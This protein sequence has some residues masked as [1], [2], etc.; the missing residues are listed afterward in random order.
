MGR[1]D[2]YL[3]ESGLIPTRSRAKRAILYG[4]IKV[5][6]KIVTK[7]AYSIKPADEVEVISEIATKPMGYWKLHFICTTLHLEIFQSSDVVLDLGSSAGG[8]LEYAAQ[9]CKKVY[10]IEIAA[11]FAPLLQQLKQQYPNIV[12]LLADAFHLDP[13]GPHPIEAIDII[14]NDLTV[15]PPESLK[16]LSKFLPLLKKRGH[17]IMSIKQGKHSTKTCRRFIE[18]RLSKKDLHII[19]LLDIDPEKKELHVIAQKP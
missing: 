9:R 1:L 17:I 16:I 10:G 12:L 11:Q 19:R 7:P 15:D 4:I 2:S 5:N 3:V 8:F 14:L 18:N 6:N 13:Q